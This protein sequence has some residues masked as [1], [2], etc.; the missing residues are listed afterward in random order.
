MTPYMLFLFIGKSLCFISSDVSC[1]EYTKYRIMKQSFPNLLVWSSNANHFRESLDRLVMATWMYSMITR[2]SLLEY[3]GEER[4]DEM[5]WKITRRSL[6]KSKRQGNN[7]KHYRETILKSIAFR[8]TLTKKL[9]ICS[10]N[11]SRFVRC[12]KHCTKSLCKMKQIVI[13][14]IVH[15]SNYL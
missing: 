5:I 14:L 2:V 10:W 12:N 4:W 13:V 8:N 7:L 6:S 11:C 1:T 3:K 15:I 9:I